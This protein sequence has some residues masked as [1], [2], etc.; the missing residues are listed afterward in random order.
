MNTTPLTTQQALDLLQRDNEMHARRFGDQVLHIQTFA[1]GSVGGSPGVGV[2]AMHSGFD[3][4]KGRWLLQPEK[5]LTTLTP[6]DVNAIRDSV[7]KAQ[8]WHAFQAWKKQQGEIDRL[9][10]A[11]KSITQAQDMGAANLIAV[12][13]LQ[14]VV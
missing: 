10:A 12:K 7:G 3:W 14:G 6:E 5:P 11:L 8:S 2:V 4:D 1:P 13:A 9:K